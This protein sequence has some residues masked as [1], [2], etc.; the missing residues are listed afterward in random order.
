[1]IPYE[2]DNT[3]IEYIH[4][5]HIYILAQPSVS[6]HTVD[7]TVTNITDSKTL[8]YEPYEH[9]NHMHPVHCRHLYMNGLQI[10]PH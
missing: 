7:I 4:K 5:S 8:I 6:S 9:V 1:M 3:V 2:D 10:L